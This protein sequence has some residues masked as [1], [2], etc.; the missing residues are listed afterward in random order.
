[1]W[2]IQILCN[3]NRQNIVKWIV[4]HHVLFNMTQNL[5]LLTYGTLTYNCNVCAEC[6]QIH[7]CDYGHD[8]E[9]R[10]FS[11]FSSLNSWY[12]FLVSLSSKFTCFVQQYAVKEGKAKEAT[13]YRSMTVSQEN[14]ISLWPF[15]L[16]QIFLMSTCLKGV[17]MN[18]HSDDRSIK[19]TLLV[20]RFA[21]CDSQV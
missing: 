4:I 1:M 18:D 21:E 20:K 3:I 5:W 7:G 16:T 2:T 10:F 11:F 9:E 13:G 8:Q 17:G 15:V 14:N 6:T 12:L 19:S